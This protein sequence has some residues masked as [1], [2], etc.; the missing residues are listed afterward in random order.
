MKQEIEDWIVKQ[1]DRH[2]GICER[3]II[4]NYFTENYKYIPRHNLKKD[5]KQMNEMTKKSHKCQRQST[6]H[7]ECQ[8]EPGARIHAYKILNSQIALF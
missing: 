6:V 7:R 3:E 4:D 2:T 1:N 8:W 5:A